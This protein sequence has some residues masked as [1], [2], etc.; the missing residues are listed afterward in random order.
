MNLETF[1]I[2]QHK[3]ITPINP[4]ETQNKFNIKSVP[5]SY[6]VVFDETVDVM[7]AINRILATN[8]LNLLL[9][10]ARVHELYG[11][12]LSHPESKTFKAPATE[13]FKTIDGML[14]IVNFMSLNEMTK[15]EK[16]I[17]VGGGIIQD[18][19]AFAAVVYK[20]GIPWVYFPT[21]LLSQSDSCI[22]GKT[23]L[24]HQSAKNQLA[25]FS[26]PS[27]V[28][29]N[30]GFLKTLALPDIQSGMGEILKL[31]IIGGRGFLDHYIKYQPE[32][33]KIP[34][35]RATKEL[36][37]GALAVKKVVIER[38]EFELDLR[39][40]LN[41][42]HTFGHAVEILS[43]YQIP[44]GQAVTVGMILV[45]ELSFRLNFL[46]K[47]NRDQIRELAFKL[48]DPSVLDIMKSLKIEGLFQL[49]KKDK[50]TRGSK[51]NFIFLYDLGDVRFFQME[52]D[53]KLIGDVTL[54]LHE[55][56]Q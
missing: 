44:H 12:A 5:R 35:A 49:L 24:N 29:I 32:P 3:F 27:E 55:I 6:P 54:I 21:T 40:S 20:R 13:E 19:G 7:L 42:G 2:S 46:S 8:P 48:L 33:G 25:L 31:H 56:F 43:N 41:Y 16:L 52:L 26:A 30:P 50:K 47:A 36:V 37:L 34:S 1:S 23:G 10:D 22:G 45:N 14:N 9:I 28:I 51:V 15:G 38:D 39:R 18:I 4:V 53:E 11:V 17:V